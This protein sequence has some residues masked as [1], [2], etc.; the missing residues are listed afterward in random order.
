MLLFLYTEVPAANEGRRG[1]HME[2]SFL[3]ELLNRKLTLGMLCEIG[4][5]KAGL[6]QFSHMFPFETAF[7]SL[8]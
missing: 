4:L 5:F 7:P 2:G 1:G 3:Q 6:Q 8:L